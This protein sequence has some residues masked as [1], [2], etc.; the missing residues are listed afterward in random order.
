MDKKFFKTKEIKNIL[1][2]IL[3]KYNANKEI[4]EDISSSLILTSLRGIDTHGISQIFNIIDRVNKK[5][6]QLIK[7]AIFDTKVNII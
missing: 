2:K 5:R 1:K 7:K 4:L 6:S 3:E